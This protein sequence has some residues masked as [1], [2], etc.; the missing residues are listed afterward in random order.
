MYVYVCNSQFRV[1]V[2]RLGRPAARGVAHTD[3]ERREQTI[4]RPY[5]GRAAGRHH[6]QHLLS[7]SG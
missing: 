4:L 6:Q 1:C 3:S 7:Q 2:L 5:G